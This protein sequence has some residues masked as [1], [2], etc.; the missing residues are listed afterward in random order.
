MSTT[1]Y[2]E[3]DLPRMSQEAISLPVRI[4]IQDEAD[5]L[6]AA[7]VWGAAGGEAVLAQC[8]PEDISLFHQSFDV[9]AARRE[10]LNYTAILQNHGVR[11]LMV[12][13]LLAEVLKPKSLTK[14]QVTSDMV[15]KA[16]TAQD[17]YGTHVR[18]AADLIVELVEQ[19]IRRY[20]EERALTLNRTLSITPQLPLGDSIYSRDQ[21]NVLLN[22]RV[23]SR[24]AKTIRRREVGLYETVYKRYISPHETITIPQGETFEG[25]DAYIHNG[26][27]FVGVGTRT[28]LG[29]AIKV[30]QILK[31]QLDRYGFLFAVVEDEEPFN[32]PFSEQQGSMHLDT[33]SNPI[34]RK[35]IAACVE[36]ARRRRI[37]FL[38][39]VGGNVIF[40]DGF[41]S[42]IDYLERTEDNI[43]VIPK[44]EQR[45]FACNFLLRGENQNGG[46]TIFVPLRSNTET[47][48]QLARLGKEIVHTD[49]LESTKGYGAAH[50]MTGQLLRSNT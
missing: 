16:R 40:N 4:G 24:M 32:K 6:Q 38:N 20:G 36:E 1:L 9:L 3:T 39:T 31:P 34:G 22:T 12:R 29:A 44:E 14:D 45:G 25:G 49:L 43:L 23:V 27:V 13:D 17:L 48:N 46:Y 19:D 7:T 18:E 42:F 26:T 30:Y 21:M 2:L 11:V 41:G 15:E 47:N 28:T 33:F 50:C 8:Y 5:S 37:R 35:E 10:G